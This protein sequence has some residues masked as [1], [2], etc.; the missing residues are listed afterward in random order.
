[1]YV[2]PPYSS[3]LFSYY[4]LYDVHN[5]VIHVYVLFCVV[6]LSTVVLNTVYH[7][8][9]DEEKFRGFRGF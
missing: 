6:S 1:M 9:F 4:N 7:E 2:E 5:H 3:Y 8:S